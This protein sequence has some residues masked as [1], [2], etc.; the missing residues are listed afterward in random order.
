MNIVGHKSQSTR[1]QP[2]ESWITTEEAAEHLCVS[3]YTVVKIPRDSIQRIIRSTKG[4]AAV[5]SGY[6][7]L[8]REVE[9]V[10]ALRCGAHI[11]LNSALRVFV[12]VRDDALKLQKIA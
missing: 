12:A 5:G 7:W 10:A 1:L 6:L 9:Y 2:D 11:S 8:R 3:A 4:N